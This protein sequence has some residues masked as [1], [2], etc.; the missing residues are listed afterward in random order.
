MIYLTVDEILNWNKRLEKSD[1]CIESVYD[2]THSYPNIR[3]CRKKINTLMTLPESEDPAIK[4]DF[5]FSVASNRKEFLHSIISILLKQEQLGTK[6]II[7]PTDNKNYKIGQVELKSIHLKDSIIESISSHEHSIGD[8]NYTRYAY[9]FVGRLSNII[10]YIKYLED[11]IIFF[12]KIWGYDE[13]GK[14]YRL[15]K[16]NIGD[17]ISKVNDKSKDLLIFD[18]FYL[19]SNHVYAIDYIACEILTNG[20]ILKYGNS[21][22]FHENEICFSRDNRLGDILN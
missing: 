20:L 21:E 6:I 8:K 14:E 7:S 9:R 4:Y 18:Y 10:A 15:L 5:I 17:V 22:I 1:Y 11:A 3:V 19:L 2:N 12:Q 13:T 16:F